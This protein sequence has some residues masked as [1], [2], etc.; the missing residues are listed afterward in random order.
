MNGIN[1]HNDF[2]IEVQGDSVVSLKGIPQKLSKETALRTAAW[3]VT[4]ADDDNRFDEI[5]EAIANA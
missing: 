1:T 5:L 2:F 3:I 4:L